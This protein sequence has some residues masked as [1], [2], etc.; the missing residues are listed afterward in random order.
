MALAQS[1]DKEPAAVLELAWFV[2]GGNLRHGMPSWSGLPEL[3][4]WQIV[5]YLKTLQ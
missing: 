3:R 5:A 2:R 4:R 1:A